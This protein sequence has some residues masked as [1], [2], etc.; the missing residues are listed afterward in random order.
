MKTLTAFVTG[1]LL[2]G[3]LLA[4][5][6]RADEISPEALKK[7]EDKQD[8]ILQV[9]DEIKSELNVVKIRVSSNG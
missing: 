4:P 9:L 8:Q 3:L 7:I 5:A 2:T 1:S 6:L